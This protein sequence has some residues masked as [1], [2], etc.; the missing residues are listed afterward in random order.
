MPEA[1][2]EHFVHSADVGVRGYGPTEE[3]AFCQAAMAMTA[4]MA[5]IDAV[6]ARESI[7]IHCRE[8]DSELLLLAWLNEVVYETDVRHMLF[9]RFDMRIE[10]DSLEALAWGEQMDPRR[11]DLLVEVKAATPAE[12]KVGHDDRGRW[13]AQCIVDV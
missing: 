13:F 9:C 5:D 10:G 12:L 7:A 6:E 2:W 4:V 11:H 8:S 1:Y 3:D